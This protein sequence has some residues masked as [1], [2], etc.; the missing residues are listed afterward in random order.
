MISKGYRAATIDV[1]V[2]NAFAGIIGKTCCR[3][4]VGRGKSLS[5]GFGERIL[6]SKP[7]VADPF[8]G[9]WEIGTYSSA[10]R[11]VDNSK[12]LCGSLDVVDSIEE[13]D[14]KLQQ[15]RLG[16]VVDIEAVSLLDIRVKLE[17]GVFVD[18]ICAS[19][20]DDEM[21]HI[22]GPDNLYIEYKNIGGWEVGKSDA[23]WAR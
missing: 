17:R 23:P 3:Q 6:Q 1:N 22:F 8:Y 13:L 9:E 11:I 7:K 15:V 19:S 12:I 21:F 16:A 4:R 10:W 14:E 18:F 5:I 2:R 20:E